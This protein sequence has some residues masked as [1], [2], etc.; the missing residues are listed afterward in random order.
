VEQALQ[1]TACS[2]ILSCVLGFET[3]LEEGIV[4]VTELTYLRLK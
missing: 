2:S 4:D 3:V 1:G